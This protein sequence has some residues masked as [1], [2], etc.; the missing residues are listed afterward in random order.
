MLGCKC[1]DRS[2]PRLVKSGQ[3]I[4]LTYRRIEWIPADEATGYNCGELN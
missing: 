4:L 1:T 2:S 3:Q